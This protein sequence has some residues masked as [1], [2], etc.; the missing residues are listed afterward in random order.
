MEKSPAFLRA[1]RQ[2]TAMSAIGRQFVRRRSRKYDLL[3][4]FEL[5][6][7]DFVDHAID[8][9]RAAVAFPAGR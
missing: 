9:D 5:V 4:Q 6:R 2:Q 1:F 7:E 3:G 8:L